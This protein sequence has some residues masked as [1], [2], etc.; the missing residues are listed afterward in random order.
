MT[1]NQVTEQDL[2]DFVVYE[3]RLLD[4]KRFDEWNAL[5]TDD[6]WYWVPLTPGQPDGINHTSHIYA[7]KLLRDVRIERL[8]SQRLFTQ[9]P[10]SR[11]QHILQLPYVD[12]MDAGNNKFVLRTPFHYAEYQSGNSTEYQAEETYILVGVAWHHLSV[13]DDALKLTLKR[14]D[15][16]NSDAAL[17]G[18]QLFV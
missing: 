12:D 13:V 17:P 1:P 6:A 7:D 11:S 2:I 18:I 9:K 3:A 5:F 14:V 10:P 4:E 8:K 15:V 16:I